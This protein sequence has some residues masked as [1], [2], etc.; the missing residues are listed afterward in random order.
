MKKLYGRW[1]QEQ[2]LDILRALSCPADEVRS[3]TL[4][5]AGE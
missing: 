4:Q 5:L 2:V 3:L 1:I